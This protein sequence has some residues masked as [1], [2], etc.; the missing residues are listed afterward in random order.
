MTVLIM[1]TEKDKNQINN[2]VQNIYCKSPLA[3]SLTR[4]HYWRH[5]KNWKPRQL[6]RNIGDYIMLFHKIL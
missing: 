5:C 6:C 1:E 2:G 4:T 3:I